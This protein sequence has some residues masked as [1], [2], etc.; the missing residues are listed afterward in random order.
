VR[1]GILPLGS[2]NVLA[3]ELGLPFDSKKAAKVIAQGNTRRIHVGC[4][5]DVESGARRYFLLMAGIGLDASV[6]RRVHPRL[7][8]RVGKAAFWVS[9]LS[10][11]ADWKPKP[12]AIEVDGN[13]YTATFATI[14]KAASYGGDLTVTPQAQ[15][16][17]PDFQICIINSTSRLRYLQLLSY[18]M[19]SGMPAGKPG[20]CLVRATRARAT[21]EAAVQVDGELIGSLP[22][23][24]EIAPDSIEVI[25]PESAP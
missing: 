11:L 15:L 17:Q 22:M 18:A 9:G 14:G 5:V 8:K 2:A 10:H 7:K 16:D 21:G 3:R 25:V 19:R 23:T 12:F 4:A 13:N 1:L 6:V 20:V 24:F